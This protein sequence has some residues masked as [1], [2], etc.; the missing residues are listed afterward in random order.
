MIITRQK[1][2]EDMLEFVKGCKKIF[3]I[4]CNLCATTCKSGGEEEVKEIAEKLKKNGKVITGT[5]VLDPACSYLELKRLYRSHADEIDSADAVISLACGGGTQAAAELFKA[6][7]VY[8]GTD[9]LFQGEITRATLK[10]RNFA[11]KCSLCGECILAVTGGICPVTRCP[12]GLLNGPCGGI[13]NGKCEV[14]KD[15]DCV[16]L[17]IYDKLRELD[18]VDLMKVVREP[19]DHSKNKKPQDLTVE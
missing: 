3:L 14:D 4:G 1:P 17:I 8:P 7:R 11:Q 2:L 13:K 15:M 18:E 19:K 16:W 10:E 6:T 9:T 5:A 12:E